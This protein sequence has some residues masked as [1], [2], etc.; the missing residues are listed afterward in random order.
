[1]SLKPLN[2]PNSLA[3]DVQGLNQQFEGLFINMMLKSMRQA[4][5]AAGQE[6]SQDSQLY[7]SMLDQQL[8]QTMAQRGIGLADMML[9]Q[10]QRQPGALSSANAA[11]ANPAGGAAAVPGQQPGV[12]SPSAST[13]TTVDAKAS[14]VGAAA[15]ATGAAAE[16]PNFVSRSFT[17]CES[18]R[19]DIFSMKETTSSL[20]TVAISYLS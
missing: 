13:G 6:Q 20:V 16:T 10:M 19:T 1:M 17:S 7:T 2:D 18:S 15:T 5:A 3:L 9:R 12:G 11:G 4:T 8:S 14:A